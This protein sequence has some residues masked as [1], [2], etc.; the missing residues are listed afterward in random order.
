[1]GLFDDQDFE[2]DHQV[3]IDRKPAYYGFANE[4]RE[5]SSEEIYALLPRCKPQKKKRA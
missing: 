2:F 5:I 3:F 1:V 4:T